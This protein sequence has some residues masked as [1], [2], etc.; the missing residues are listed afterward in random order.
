MTNSNQFYIISK[1]YPIRNKCTSLGRDAAFNLELAALSRLKSFYQCNCG[2]SKCHFPVVLETD[3][4]SYTIKMS[5]CGKNMREKE[6]VIELREKLDNQQLNSQIK[7]IIDNLRRAGVK[8]AD[9]AESGQNLCFDHDTLC[10]IDFD[11]ALVQGIKDNKTALRWANNYAP[12]NQYYKFF[13]GQIMIIIN[14]LC[15]KFKIQ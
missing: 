3:Y 5:H 10:L 4:S 8:H 6:A 15:S 14:G 11:I 1:T 9:C 2:A 13:A 12:G 7:C